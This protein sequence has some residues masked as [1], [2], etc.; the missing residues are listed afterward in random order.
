MRKKT[1]GL[2]TLQEKTE[3][4]QYSGEATVK[5]KFLFMNSAPLKMREATIHFVN[6]CKSK[7]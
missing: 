2:H 5:L 7:Q 3:F 4:W 6:Q 1:R